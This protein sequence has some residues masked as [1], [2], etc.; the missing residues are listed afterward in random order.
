MKLKS[1]CTFF[2]AATVALVFS[3][4]ATQVPYDYTAFKES[5]P[6][7]ILVLP[8]VNNSPEVA[9]SYSVLS[10]ATRPL[11][12]AGYYVMPVTLVA[13]AFKENGM[14]QPSDMHATSPEK[15]QEIFGADS[16]LYITISKYGTT[17]QIID[18]ETLVAAQAKLIDL[19]TGKTLWTGVAQASSSEGNNQ[20][21]GGLAVL[22]IAAIIKQVVASTTDH[23]HQV[24]GVATERLLSAGRKNGL[25]YGPRSP[26][27][28]KDPQP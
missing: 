14:T 4:C 27:F 26:N 24:A 22:L 19:K 7:S 1:Y 18:S 20:N 6:R 2:C 16:A 11:A 8:P 12:E 9:A 21:Q 28:G 17:F 13:E 25:L 5:H 15:L 10:Y 23:G 3:G